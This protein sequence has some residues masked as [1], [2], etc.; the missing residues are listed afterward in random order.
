MA[1]CGHQWDV[2][3]LSYAS[4]SDHTI[5]TYVHGHKILPTFDKA[6]IIRVIAFYIVKNAVYLVNTVKTTVFEQSESNLHSISMALRAKPN[7]IMGQIR[8]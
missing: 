6:V 2:I 8:S 1:S 3:F 5:C 7:L 4:W